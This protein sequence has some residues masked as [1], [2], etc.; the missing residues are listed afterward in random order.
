[1]A[2]APSDAGRDQLLAMPSRF[3]LGQSRD[4]CAIKTLER[5]RVNRE[6][7]PEQERRRNP[8]RPRRVVMRKAK[9]PQDGECARNKHGPGR[10]NQGIGSPPPASP[11]SDKRMQHQP[12]QWNGAVN[13]TYQHGEKIDSV[14]QRHSIRMLHAAGWSTPSQAAE[15]LVASFLSSAEADSRKKIRSLSARLKSCPDTS[16]SKPEFFRSLFRLA[17]SSAIVECALAPEVTTF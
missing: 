14:A 12:E 11:A 1:M 6:A 5:C 9:R 8:R 3:E 17:Y 15:T 4:L 16:R 7:G 10:K 13:G 2:H